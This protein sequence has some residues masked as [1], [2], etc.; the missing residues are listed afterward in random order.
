MAPVRSV[1]RSALPWLCLVQR[2]LTYKGAR[3]DGVW[4]EVAP[5]IL[6]IP[7]WRPDFCQELIDV[8]ELLDEFKPYAPDVANDA[9]PGQELRINRISPRLAEYFATHFQDV[10]SP[11]IKTHW[12]PLGTGK[13][14]MPFVLRYSPDT[15]A[16]LNPHHDSALVSLAMPLNNGYEGGWLTFPRQHWDSREVGV[17]QLIAFPSRVTHV[18]GVTAVTR[19]T[20]YA[21]TCWIAAPG[22]QPDDAVL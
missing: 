19:G 14:R 20:R 6:L 5:D 4:R 1:W 21:M 12:W 17:G 3:V 9:A 18:H 15:Q 2:L 22:E 11:I 10:V 8:A 16:T 13:V 7:F